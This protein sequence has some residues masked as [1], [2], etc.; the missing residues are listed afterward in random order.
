M[1]VRLYRRSA[2]F[3]FQRVALAIH[4]CENYYYASIHTAE[5]T[6]KMF[7]NFQSW[8]QVTAN[9]I[10]LRLFSSFYTVL[11]HFIWLEQ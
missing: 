7:A 6:V 3:S 9:C 11:L 5:F 10:N 4:I 2:T 1:S 8:F